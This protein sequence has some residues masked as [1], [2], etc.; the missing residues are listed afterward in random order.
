[1]PRNALANVQVHYRLTL[2]EMVP[3]IERLVSEAIGAATDAPRDLEL[4]VRI[5]E[6]AIQTRP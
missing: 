1:M 6:S 2:A 3:A 5:A 4:E